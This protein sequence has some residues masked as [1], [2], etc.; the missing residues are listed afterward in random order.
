[1]TATERGFSGSGVSRWLLAALMLL[2]VYTLSACHS[3]SGR[4]KSMQELFHSIDI[5]ESSRGA[6]GFSMTDMHGQQR[7][8]GDFKGQ[9]V[10]VFFGFVQCPD[11]CPTTLAELAAVKKKL[12]Q[13][14]PGYGERVQGIFITVDPERD[15]PEVLRAYMQAFDR[16]FLALRSTPDATRKLADSFQV[17]YKQIPG[18][19]EGTYTIDHTAASFV[20]DPQ[21]RIRLLTRYR[22]GVDKWA[23]DIRLL[24]DGS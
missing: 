5:A 10:V 23:E 12:N 21:G 18:T 11:V 13:M 8:L 4:A 17:F 9:V 3:G 1:M 6:D 7:T 15:T 19:V 2:A 20:F 22:M 16:S 14:K 24:L